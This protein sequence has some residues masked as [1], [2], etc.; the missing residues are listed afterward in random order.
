MCF[1]PFAIM[2]TCHQLSFF[3][4]EVN[5]CKIQPIP[6]F[7]C[8]HGLKYPKI[9]RNRI[10]GKCHFPVFQFPLPLYKK[11]HETFVGS[12][13]KAHVMYTELSVSERYIVLPA[14]ALQEQKN[15]PWKEGTLTPG[16]NQPRDLVTSREGE[17]FCHLWNVLRLFAGCCRFFFVVFELRRKKIFLWVE[18]TLF[19][20]FFCLKLAYFQK[21]FNYD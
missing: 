14:V 5:R 10:L 2:A 13:L 4:A 17:K 19:N 7:P 20:L 1:Q 9:E 8:K 16:E 15:S 11:K 12:M 6:R 18:L 21:A 3:I